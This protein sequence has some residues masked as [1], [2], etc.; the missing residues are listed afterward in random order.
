MCV[1][2]LTPSSSTIASHFNAEP[3]AEVFQD[4][5]APIIR[6]GSYGGRQAALA[7]FGMIPRRQLQPDARAYA[8]MNARSET[9]GQKPAFARCWKAGQ[10]CLIPMLAF[11]EP[12]WET[13][14]S[15]RWRIGL[16]DD[17]PFAVA[18]LWRSWREQDHSESL[19]FT[20]ITINVDGHP[21]LNRFHKPPPPGEPPDKRSLVI[22]RPEDYD[23]WLDCRDPEWART[24][25]H[26]TPVELLQAAPAPI[27]SRSKPVPPAAPPS[28]QC[29]LF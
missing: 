28:G 18:G 2:F 25:L 1:N 16:A 15:V 5:L 14:R 26:S 6:H 9:L 11:F 7:S 22:L 13:G 21:L 29:E 23:A 27:V 17:A 24:F 10:L 20:A 4:Y 3:P 12:N 8:T 19:S